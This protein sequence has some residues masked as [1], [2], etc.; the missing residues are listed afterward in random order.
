MGEWS[1][2]FCVIIMDTSFQLLNLFRGLFLL[3]TTHRIFLHNGKASPNYYLIMMGTGCVLNKRPN[4][5]PT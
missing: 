2:V 3:K 1:P 4:G 5:V